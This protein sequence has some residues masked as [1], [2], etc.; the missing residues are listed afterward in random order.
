M[1][2][3]V[4]I[5]H[6]TDQLLLITQGDHAALAGHPCARGSWTRLPDHPRRDAILCGDRRTTTMAGAKKMPSCT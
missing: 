5:R 1:I 6:A 3:R 2:V 4:I